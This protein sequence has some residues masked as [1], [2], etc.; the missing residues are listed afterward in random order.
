[1][2]KRGEVYW[3]KLDPSVGSEVKKTARPSL[4]PPMR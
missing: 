1:M 4:S 3:V 2:V